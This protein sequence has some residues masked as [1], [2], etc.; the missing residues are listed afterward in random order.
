MSFFRAIHLNVV[1]DN[2]LCIM[3]VIQPWQFSQIQLKD[4]LSQ[5]LAPLRQT[6]Q[7]LLVAWSMVTL[8]FF[9]YMAEQS[10]Q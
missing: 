8:I 3:E 2:P 6:P 9:L 4:H 5:Q 1:R 10:C 7:P